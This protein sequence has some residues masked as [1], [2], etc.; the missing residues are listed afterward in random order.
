MWVS[1]FTPKQ[2]CV[3]FILLPS[4]TNHILTQGYWTKAHPRTTYTKSSTAW[5]KKNQHISRLRSLMESLCRWCQLLYHW[6]WDPSKWQVGTNAR[7]TKRSLSIVFI[8][9]YEVLKDQS[10]YPSEGPKEHRGVYLHLVSLPARRSVKI[11]EGRER[12]VAEMMTKGALFHKVC[13]I[14]LIT[15]K[16]TLHGAIEVIH[17]KE[18]WAKSLL[19]P[20][21]KESDNGLSAESHANSRGVKH[22]TNHFFCHQ[23]L[24][25]LKAGCIDRGRLL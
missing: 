22:L 5:L 11:E 2:S 20:S 12:E 14:S 25:M 10:C 19:F 21:K 13:I 17:L 15:Y 9:T 18:E 24:F 3:L 4:H 7:P 1:A 6:W 8:S 23:L 16:S